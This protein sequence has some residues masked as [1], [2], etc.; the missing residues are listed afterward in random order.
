MPRRF[1]TH[2]DLIQGLVQGYGTDTLLMD[3]LSILSTPTISN[4]GADYTVVTADR[5]T[6]FVSTATVTFTLLAAAAGEGPFRF[7]VGSAN[8]LS[9]V[10][11]AGDTIYIGTTASATGWQS[12]LDIGSALELIAID[13]TNWIAISN[14]G[15]WL[16]IP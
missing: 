4:K 12:S 8:V 14:T 16:A 11:D 5:W 3:D 7:I 10:P 15:S 1:L 13:A 2:L 9:V 6:Y